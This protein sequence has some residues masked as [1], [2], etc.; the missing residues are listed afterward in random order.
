MYRPTNRLSWLLLQKMATAN[1]SNEDE[2]DE[3]ERKIS[4]TVRKLNELQTAKEEQKTLNVVLEEIINQKE[5]KY[6]CRLHQL[7]SEKRER[8]KRQQ[9]DKRLIALESQMKRMRCDERLDCDNPAIQQSVSATF[10]AA[11]ETAAS[12]NVSE[13]LKLENKRLS[14]KLN[15]TRQTLSDVQE[16]LTV[17]EQATAATRQRERQESTTSQ[18]QN[19]ELNPQHQPTTSAGLNYISN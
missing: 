5:Q 1:E 3:L 11:S 2:D 19:V 6:I 12:G 15:E 7:K 10:P 17:H 13:L 14:N 16:R 9:T 18:E 4:D 8:E